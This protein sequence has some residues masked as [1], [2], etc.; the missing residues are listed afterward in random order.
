MRSFIFRKLPS[1][2]QSVFANNRTGSRQA[3]MLPVML[4]ICGLL[5][6]FCWCLPAGKQMIVQKQELNT[7]DELKA[8]ADDLLLTRDLA[9]RQADKNSSGLKKEL[10]KL[11]T[12]LSDGALLHQIAGLIS[13][14]NLI[15]LYF[16]PG[17][18]TRQGS[19]LN[20]DMRYILNG[21]H[22]QIIDFIRQLEKETDMITIRSINMIETVCTDAEEVLQGSEQLP[23]LTPGSGSGYHNIY[24]G[25]ISSEGQ[26]DIEMTVDIVLTAYAAG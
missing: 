17:V 8:R 7:A 18:I 23:Y 25:G 19:L 14:G 26:D 6:L 4:F 13:A 9:K 24:S 5:I 16:D 15:V 12:D 11:N 10:G 3:L 21:D 20:R 1:K 2:K 22:A